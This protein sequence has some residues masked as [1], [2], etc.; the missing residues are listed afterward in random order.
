[1]GIIAGAAALV[2]A[3]LA[4]GGY[5]AFQ[6]S[7]EDSAEEHYRLA[8]EL[9]YEGK[10]E[11]AISEYTRVLNIDDTFIEAYSNRGVAHMDLGDYDEA[12]EDFS[13]AIRQNPVV[14]YFYYNRGLAF[15]RAGVLDYALLDYL[16]AV[17]LDQ[18]YRDAF[19][20][21]GNVYL[22]YGDYQRAGLELR[23]RPQARA[24]ES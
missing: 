21:L 14:P 3:L 6:V 5:W 18:S 13:N 9:Q 11:R 16:D 19:Y 12:V 8:L 2:I 24:G 23:Q 1:M 10:L 15:E 17:N 20:G 22:Q 4:A 7:G